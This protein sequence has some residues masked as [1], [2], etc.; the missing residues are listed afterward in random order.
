M[1]DSFS[2]AT[3][4]SADDVDPHRW[5]AHL[6][7]GWDTPGGVH[8]GVLLAT[9]VRA[10]LAGVARPELTLRLA[11]A[12]F[13]APPSHDLFFD[14]TVLRQ[15]RGSAH[16]RALGTCA[17]E[18]HPAIDVTIVL[19]ADRD[20]PSLAD[21]DMP[22]VP[23]AEGL[24]TSEGGPL[25]GAPGLMAPPPLFDHLDVRTAHGR[26][27]WED[28]WQPGQGARHARWA[29][30]LERPTTPDGEFD[31]LALLP[32]ADLPGPSIWQQFGPDEP[33]LFFLSLDLSLN[34]LAPVRDDWILTDIRTRSLQAGHAHVE[35]DL[36]SAG[37]L[38][39]TSA[40]TM[41][42]RTAFPSG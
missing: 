39:A 19:T 41:M 1:T 2:D 30:Y 42:I 4:V 36:W 6:D 16:V 40:Q 28:G 5:H 9:G 17:R 21:R 8:G 33:M 24:T 10:A 15:G 14:V 37:R 26:L 18:Q 13:L 38:V 31:R 20:S 25:R 29:R 34:L 12:V 3:A 22:D 11:H 27:P 32:L 23:P 35:T 7:P